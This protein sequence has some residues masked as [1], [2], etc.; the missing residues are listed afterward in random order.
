MRL[1]YPVDH[2]GA[3]KEEL[4]RR[5]KAAGFQ[6]FGVARAEPLGEELAHLRAWLAHGDAAGM[7]FMAMHAKGRCD[8]GR[9]LKGARSVVMVGM[10][11]AQEPPDLSL[12]TEQREGQIA[13]FALGRDYHHVLQ[14]RLEQMA[15]W[16]EGETQGEAKSRCV[17]DTGPLLE[18][19]FAHRAGLGFVG[20]N[21]CL[22]H[23]LYGSWIFLAALITNVEMTADEP[24]GSRCH[25]CRL[26]LDACP[27]GALYEPFRL[28]A[29]RCLAYWTVE[30]H[31]SMETR[32]MGGMGD[33]LFGCDACQEVCPFNRAALRCEEPELYPGFA[34]GRLSG[35]NA[36]LGAIARIRSNREFQRAFRGSSLA[37]AR[38]KGM[39]RN[40]A[41]VAGNL[42]R[43]DLRET[44]K[45]LADDD[46]QAR[47]VRQS[48]QWA[49]ERLLR[50]YVD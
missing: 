45:K 27:T 6:L 28:D 46:K 14:P 41:V 25:G 3:L 44:L 34:P 23:P 9:L 12:L 21:T 47:A 35:S 20:K 13:R 38:L 17:V 24:M 18:R 43:T 16:L 29:R 50:P 2:D 40:A 48:A 36:T 32:I 1:A 49:M 22:T 10:S 5:A 26:C 15:R 4:S 19:A 31:G 8:P 39:L 37:R 30:D 11:Y 33:R 42:G 7:A